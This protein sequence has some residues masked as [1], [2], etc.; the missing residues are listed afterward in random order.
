MEWWSDGVVEAKAEVG[1]EMDVFEQE[2]TERTEGKIYHGWTRMG[3]DKKA[4]SGKAGKR[5]WGGRETVREK[6]KLGKQKARTP[7]WGLIMEETML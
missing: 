4:E 6:Q 2:A 7:V 5:K 1:G 3:R